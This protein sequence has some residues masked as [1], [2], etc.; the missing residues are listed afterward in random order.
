MLWG[1]FS[2]KGIGQLHL[3]KGKMDRAMY[4]QSQDIEASQGIENWSWMD[5]PALQLPKTH[6]QCNKRVAQ[7]EAH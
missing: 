2:T 4:R 1:C 6:G 5:I 3:I 7:E